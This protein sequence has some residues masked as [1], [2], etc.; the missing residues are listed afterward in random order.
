MLVALEQ[1]RAVAWDAAL[2]LDDPEAEGRH[3]AVMAAGAVALDAFARIAKD[4]IQ[5]LGGIG[6]TWEH[7]AHLYLRRAMALRQL[8]G[9][10]GPWRADVGAATRSAGERRHLTLDLPAGGRVDPRRDRGDRRRDRRR[11]RRRSDARGSPTP[12]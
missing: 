1:A 8:L 5:V 6:F 2:A 7:D 10:G 4:C 9:G 12:G 3:L 11:A